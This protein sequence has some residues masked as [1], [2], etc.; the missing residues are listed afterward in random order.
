MNQLNLSETFLN[1]DKI[2]LSTQENS[3]VG[4][5]LAK[6]ATD[7]AQ[8]QIAN[9]ATLSATGRI[10]SLPTLLDFLK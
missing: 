6:S 10:L 7:L 4:A 1:Q 9:Q 2:S 8:A 5:D 3:L